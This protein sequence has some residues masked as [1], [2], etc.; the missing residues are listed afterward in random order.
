M[1][2]V[3]PPTS[4]HALCSGRRTYNKEGSNFHVVC[5]DGLIFLVIASENAGQTKPFLFLDECAR[6]FKQR[7]HL[8]AV[9]TAVAFELNEFSKV[10]EE[11]MAFYSAEA[12]DPVQRVKGQLDE[13]KGVMVSNLE[14]VLER[15]EKLE[16]LVEKTE[17]LQNSAFNFRRE[18]RVLH[19]TFFW[20]NIR[21]Y[22]VLVLAAALTIYF[23]LGLACGFKLDRC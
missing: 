8:S 23:I 14:K 9:S 13:V 19:R 16:M 5:E 3:V 17:L 18:A 21:M 22:V 15:G 20:R 12:S 6:L 11:R 7:W 4:C 2:P 10:L 1:H